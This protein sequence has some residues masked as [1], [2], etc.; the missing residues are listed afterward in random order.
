M[1]SLYLSFEQMQLCKPVDW[2]PN[3]QLKVLFQ[4][5]YLESLFLLVSFL[6]SQKLYVGSYLIGSL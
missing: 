6:F 1:N 5:L 2:T 4:R 3:E